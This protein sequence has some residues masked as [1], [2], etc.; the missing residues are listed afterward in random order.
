MEDNKFGLFQYASLADNL[1]DSKSTSGGFMELDHTHHLNHF[2]GCVRSS[3]QFRAAVQNL[4][5]SHWL[6]VDE[7]MCY[8]RDLC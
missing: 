6:Q 3:H 1:R 4:K 2:L 5:S 7:W 8:Q